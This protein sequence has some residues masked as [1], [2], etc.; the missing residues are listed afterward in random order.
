MNF[1]KDQK[2][3]ETPL[4]FSLIDSYTNQWV[5]DKSSVIGFSLKGNFSQYLQSNFK[6]GISFLFQFT[7]K[8]SIN[9]EFTESSSM[10]ILNPVFD[11]KEQKY[12]SE[13]SGENWNIKGQVGFE[14]LLPD[15]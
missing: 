7:N 10:I 14:E 13:V 11:F 4:K 15:Q 5:P 3:V 1:Y 8:I 2:K 12:V 9:Q 6:T